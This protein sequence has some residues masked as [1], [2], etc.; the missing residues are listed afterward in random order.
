MAR[1]LVAQGGL[2][3]S[4]LLWAVGHTELPG[5]RVGTYVIDWR[6]AW[7][8]RGP[9]ARLLLQALR[10]RVWLKRFGRFGDDIRRSLLA[11][12]WEDASSADLLHRFR[13]RVQLINQMTE[14]NLVL[15]A[16]RVVA[17][18]I[19]CW[20]LAPVVDSV[21][22]FVNDVYRRGL[23]TSSARQGRALLQL[24]RCVRVGE[25]AS[26]YLTKRRD[27]YE[28]YRQVLAGTRF[29]AE[30]DRF[31]EQYGGNATFE[32]DL[33]WPRHS[34]SPPALLKTIAHMASSEVDLTTDDNDI[35]VNK[36]FKLNGGWR[37]WL[38]RWA[39]GWARNL[40]L[41]R[42]ELRGLYGRSMTDCR[43]WDLDLAKRWQTRDWLSEPEDYFWLTMKEIERALMAEA[44]TGPTL[45]A[46]VRGRRE[47]Y[48]TY[49]STNMPY[50]LRES[51]VARLIPGEGLQEVGLSSVMSG[52]PVSPGQV[53]GRVLVL[54]QPE[55]A[56]R[57]VEG[58][59]LVTPSTD[60]A[61]FS[62]FPQARGLIVETG[63]L[64]S[65]G[66]I[67]AREFG[68]PAVANIPDA[69]SRFRDGD[70]VLLDGS[71]GVV[72]ILQSAADCG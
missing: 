55:D 30:F 66:S 18:G 57:M 1:R 58:A 69:T 20:A 26:R 70:L 47:T 59:I 43:T 44:E 27:D 2:N 54:C 51:D 38:G 64:L 5:E 34:E 13:L 50:A 32:A 68:L 23:E 11:T 17:A 4:G 48:Q 22:Q 39:I 41:V 42:D 14:A 36:G 60:P 67:I 7:K 71:T 12:D 52:L 19:A 63:G 28:E 6:Q 46:I 8:S 16:A 62:V 33:G 49:A 40:T 45:P 10:A 56:T 15:T 35:H 3:P 31:L 37:G 9:L 53:Q 24:A 72:Q 25:K 61:W 65:H 21:G 29:L